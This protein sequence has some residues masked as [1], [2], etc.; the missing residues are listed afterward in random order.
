MGGAM[1]TD[2]TDDFFGGLCHELICLIYDAV[3][4]QQGFFP[5]LKRFVE[6]FDG[7][8]ASFSI[9]DTDRKTLVGSWTVNIPEAALQFYSEH[10]AS[11]D[12][13]VEKAIAVRQGGELRFVASN[14]D[15]GPDIARIREET[16]AGEWLASYGADEAAGAIAYIDESYLNFFGMQRGPHQA[17][18]TREELRVFDGFLPH[19]SRAV[20]L[21]TRLSRRSIEPLA[22]RLAL[23][24]VNRGI[25]VCDSTF[26]VVFRNAMADNILGRRVGIRLNDNGTLSAYGN[27][28]AT[29]FTV[30]L[31]R[32][33]AA[34]VRCQAIDDRI[35][36]IQNGAHRLTI[37][38]T[39]LIGGHRGMGDQRGALITLYDW[40]IEPDIN[41]DLLREMYALTEAETEVATGLVRGESVLQIAE[42]SGRS[43]E[44]IKYH[45][46][47]LF[48]KTDTCRQGE[49]ISLLSRSCF[50]A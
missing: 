32:A 34:S 39:P 48:R 18:F 8:S 4:D 6:V 11:Q 9:Y 49:L 36:Q 41:R 13:L 27:N 33:V 25:L 5:F 23:N 10:V 42:A 43:R 15:F 44:T 14:L 19:I 50:T 12:V 22:E 47:S 45:L 28:A 29:R 1:K 26:R 24:R 35:L 46:N 20:D 38:I 21:Y 30:L 16:R 37:V 2:N 3:T 31:S 7:H 17:K 40:S